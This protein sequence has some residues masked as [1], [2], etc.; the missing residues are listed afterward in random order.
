MQRTIFIIILVF[1]F[2]NTA[3]AQVAITEIMYDLEGSDS[4]REWVEIHN[5]S[6]AEIDLADWKLYENNTNHGIT[7]IG[8]NTTLIRGCSQ[9]QILK[10]DEVADDWN[11][12][13][14]SGAAGGD[15][16]SDPVNSNILSAS[17]DLPWSIWAIMQKLRIS[18][19]FTKGF[20]HL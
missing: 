6:S 15:A 14:D 8:D 9:D 20:Y 3:F 7:G 13:A 1:F 12:S 16:W 5:T 4:G 17:V 10:W 19:V 2:T 11:C 18:S